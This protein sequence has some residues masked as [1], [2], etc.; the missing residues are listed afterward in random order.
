MEIKSQKGINRKG[1]S[2][3]GGSE[4]KPR[5]VLKS[6]AQ[7][8]ATSSCTALWLGKDKALH[9]VKPWPPAGWTRVPAVALQAWLAGH[10]FR[11]TT[12][13]PG[14]HLIYGVR[15]SVG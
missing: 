14:I 12:W 5:V 10:L 7:R 9:C 6:R 11:I 8:A 13:T 3:E 4:K 1:E 2:G 15:V